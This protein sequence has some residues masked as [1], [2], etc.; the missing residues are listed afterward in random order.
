VWWWWQRGGSYIEQ[1]LIRGV[2]ECWHRD[3]ANQHTQITKDEKDTGTGRQGQREDKG[4]A[5][6]TQRNAG[7]SSSRS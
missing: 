5:Q 2:L 3:E 6:T 4:H 1:L 7:S